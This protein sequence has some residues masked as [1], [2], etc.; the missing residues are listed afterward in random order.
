M[1][2]FELWIAYVTTI[3]I[4][5][6]TPGPS[7]LLMMSNS[8]VSGFHKSLAT[9][10][11][12]LTANSLQILL[13]ALGLVGL[14]HTMPILFIIVKW[15]GV[16]Y[17]V[18]LGGKLFVKPS[19]LSTSKKEE[20]HDIKTLFLQGFLTSLA[21]PKAILFFAA[22][23]PQFVDTSRPAAFQFLILG[24]T[25]IIIDGCFLSVYGRAAEWIARTF[26]AQVERYLGRVSGCLVIGAALLLA[27]KEVG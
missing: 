13:A 18:Y 20:T 10:I 27:V 2:S 12:D 5:M 4:L 14:F 7:Q 15:L 1:V 19:L 23:L 25:Y 11:G 24:V 17:L 21:N 8:M 9:A 16:A 22:L 26:S 3:L 6:S